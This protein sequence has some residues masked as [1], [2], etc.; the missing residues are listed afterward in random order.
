MF[1][2]L[3]ASVAACL[4]LVASASLP[5]RADITFLKPDLKL[6]SIKPSSIGPNYA[7]VIITNQGFA[8]AGTCKLRIVVHKVPSVVVYAT[9]PAMPASSGI[10]MDV[11]LGT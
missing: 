2:A 5:A 6:V 1:S 3:R 9:V 4:L 11:Y 10:G 7:R 8:G